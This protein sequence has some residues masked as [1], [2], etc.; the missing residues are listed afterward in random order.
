[1]A[2]SA[3]TVLSV[4]L[5][6]LFSKFSCGFRFVFADK[7]H[8]LMMMVERLSPNIMALDIIWNESLTFQF[9][10][11]K[12]STL[13][14]QWGSFVVATN[15]LYLVFRWAS[16]HIIQSVNT[17]TG[18]NEWQ[19][20]HKGDHLGLHNGC[21]RRASYSCHWSLESRL[22]F[23]AT[24]RMRALFHYLWYI[25]VPFIKWDCLNLIMAISIPIVKMASW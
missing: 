5:W 12:N 14:V 16:Y 7:E 24:I 18:S 19:Q 20:K 25:G 2:S 23:K 4:E 17:I 15:L 3:G 6:L 9:I 11:S 1:M 21:I 8:Y 13:S 22:I 10:P